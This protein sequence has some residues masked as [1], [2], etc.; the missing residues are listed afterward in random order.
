MDETLSKMDQWVFSIGN[1][2]LR[3]RD[4][5]PSL[6]NLNER[7]IQELWKSMKTGKQGKLV[8]SKTYNEADIQKEKY[9]AEQ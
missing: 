6:V 4:S 3:L 9:E 8:F 2:E 7:E 5:S 1:L